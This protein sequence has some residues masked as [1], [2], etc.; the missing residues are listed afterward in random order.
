MHVSGVV[1]GKGSID[2][3]ESRTKYFLFLEEFALR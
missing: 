2:L 3:L 1:F